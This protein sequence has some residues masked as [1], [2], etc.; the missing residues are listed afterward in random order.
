MKKK[1][2]N[3]MVH[4]HQVIIPVIG[5]TFEVTTKLFLVA[6]RSHNTKSHQNASIYHHRQHQGQYQKTRESFAFR[7][8]H[9]LGE[10]LEPLGGFS[11]I[12][13]GWS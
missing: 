3:A 5:M 4:G 1:K 6:I 7:S 8:Y 12:T 2:E 11:P 13:N 10:H 9:S